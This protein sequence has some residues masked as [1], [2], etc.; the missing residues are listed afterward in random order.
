MRTIKPQH[1]ILFLTAVIAACLVTLP[2]NA[3]KRQRQKAQPKVVKQ[4]EDMTEWTENPICRTM[5]ID[6][7]VVDVDNIIPSIPLPHY[8]GHFFK[9]KKSGMTIYENEFGDH[10]LFAVADTSGYKR[11]YHTILLGDEWSEAEEVVV[12]GTCYDI[13]NPYPMPDGQTLYFAARNAED[14]E[15]RCLSLY[16]TTY[17]PETNTYLAPQRMPYPFNS[18][19][20]ELYY[21]D[22]DSDSLAWL[23]TTRRQEEGKACIY[24]MRTV[25]PWEFYDAETTDPHMLKRLATI[26]SIADTW[27][28]QTRKDDAVR[29]LE[30]L[31][32][33]RHRKQRLD[34]RIHF[35]V[36]DSKTY[37]QTSQFSCEESR[38][39]FGEYMAKKEKTEATER[40]LEA[41]RRLYH[42]SSAENRQ[43][44]AETITEAETSLREAYAETKAIEQRI[45]LIEAG[46]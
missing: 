28:S 40:Q 39:L 2:A 20:D 26:A 17:D 22:D 8:A 7:L 46:E 35:V 4:E 31:S 45:R 15:G 36:N 34:G 44:I 6:S 9:D 19:S 3:Q 32:E 5:I 30:M 43:R 18:D 12:N 41:Y 29:T 24:V 42:N 1:T 13:Q 14:N 38:S 33:M 25:Q 23:A 37:T 11:L 21:I 16:T 10:R 27:T